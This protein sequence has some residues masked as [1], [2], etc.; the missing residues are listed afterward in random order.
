MAGNCTEWWPSRFFN[1]GK[2]AAPYAVVILNQP[3]NEHAL[4]AVINDATLLVCADG[5]ANRLF[6]LGKTY[7]RDFSQVRVD[8]IVGDLDSLRPQVEEYFRQQG[9]IVEKEPDQYS[10]DFR[11]CLKWIRRHFEQ[12]R[13]PGGGGDVP[14]QVDV[15]AIGGLGGRV[16]QGLSQIHHLYLALDDPELLDGRIYLL[17]E[18]SLSFVLEVGQNVIHVDQDTFNENVGI[19]PILGPATITTKGLEW[20][21]E[22]W[23]TEFGGQVSTSNHIRSDKLEISFEGKRPLFTVELGDRFTA[24]KDG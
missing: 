2:P 13:V 3:I 18:Q 17:S 7:N 23:K 15:V 20:D 5:G 24:T 8:A 4:R 22:N 6:D 16:D 9:V 12:L 14:P 10:T 11:K 21:V 19:I 1:S